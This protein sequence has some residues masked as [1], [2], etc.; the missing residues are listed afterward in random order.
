MVIDYSNESS[1][2]Q[3]NDT[4]TNAAIVRVLDEIIETALEAQGDW[5]WVLKDYSPEWT[6]SYKQI[7]DMAANLVTDLT[8]RER[9]EDEKSRLE[10]GALEMLKNDPKS[11]LAHEI[12]M[13][14]NAT[15]L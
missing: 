10:R 6:H 12:L 13:G 14:V 4:A 5:A 7:V 3:V 15:I 2:E 1:S 9:A 8:D 11:E